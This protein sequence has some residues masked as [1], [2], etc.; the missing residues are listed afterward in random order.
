M[1]YDAVL[2]YADEEHP[3][4]YKY[5]LPDALLGDAD[6]EEVTLAQLSRIVENQR[7]VQLHDEDTD[8]FANNDPL[9]SDGESDLEDLEDANPAHPTTNQSTTYKLTK[10]EEWVKVDGSNARQIEPVP[11]EGDNEL[12]TPKI[13]SDELE[14]LKDSAGDIRFES[15]FEWMLPK[16]TVGNTEQTYF[17]FIAARMRNYMLHI[18]STKGFKPKFYNPS[19]GVVI[20]DH[21]V[22]RFFGVHLA[23]MIA[24]F[25]SID[26]TWSTRESLKHVGAAAECMPKNAYKDMYRCMQRSE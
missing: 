10:P 5:Q 20:Q 13:T 16:F 8:L 3:N 24:G 4:F 22:A 25:P 1:R 23:R 19:K 6:E 21:H 14:S 18:I 7:S 12:F 15:V 17:Q 9:P 2:H 11:F 26:N